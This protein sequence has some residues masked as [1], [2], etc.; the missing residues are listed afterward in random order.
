MEVRKEEYMKALIV[1][2]VQNDFCPGG[3]LAVP[4]G[5]EVVAVINRLIM[6]NIKRGVTVYTK[7]W[8]P[9]NHCSFKANGGIWPEH[10]VQDTKGAELHPQLCDDMGAVFLKATT[11]DADSYSG[12][13]GAHSVTGQ[14]LK[15]FLKEAGVTEVM[16]VGLALDYCVKAT[17]LDSVKYGFKTSV[18]LPA[19][20]S[21]N[22][23][24]TDEA[25]AIENLIATGVE[26]TKS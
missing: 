24:S 21:V 10:C 15:D 19:T 7:D 23:K 14:T 1:V 26:V 13:G 12:F 16:V 22:V 3:A 25:E 9:K 2:D 20:R 11:P 4:K 17:A 6:E 8:H 18:Y 5:D